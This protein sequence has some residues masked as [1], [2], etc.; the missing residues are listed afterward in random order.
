MV[1]ILVIESTPFNGISYKHE[2]LLDDV[3]AYNKTYIVRRVKNMI[4]DEI[5][6]KLMPVYAISNPK[7]N[8]KFRV[9][10]SIVRQNIRFNIYEIER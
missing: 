8:K 1:K 10:R 9:L 4:I 3:N 5:T 2:I 7:A 6:R